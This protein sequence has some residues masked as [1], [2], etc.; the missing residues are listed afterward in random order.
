MR[1]VA[2]G[3][4]LISVTQ[5]QGAR[6]RARKAQA[7]RAVLRAAG[8]GGKFEPQRAS[9][10]RTA[11]KEGGGAAA[12]ASP[13]RRA[14]GEKERGPALADRPSEPHAVGWPTAPSR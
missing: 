10:T 14:S 11:T 5:P 12:G 4:A 13:R 9:W 6:R 1:P 7:V 8:A 3:S 2:T